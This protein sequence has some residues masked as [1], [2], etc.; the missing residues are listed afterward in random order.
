MTSD[1]APRPHVEEPSWLRIATL[2]AVLSTLLLLPFL[3]LDRGW[4]PAD[5]AL[6]HVAKAVSGRSWHDVLVIRPDVT[7][8]QHPG[9][10]AILAFV[11]RS[12]GFAPGGL[13]GFSVVFMAVLVMTAPIPGLRHRE[14]WLGAMAIA[15]V[16]EPS[17]VTRLFLGRPYLVSVAVLLYLL[18][19][20]RRL[21]Q[22]KAGRL[23]LWSLVVGIAAATWIHGSPFLW[24]IPL[25]AFV[26]SAPT[27]V[28]LRVSVAMALGVTL[29][30]IATGD[31]WQFLVQTLM[32]A[33]RAVG[34]DVPEWMLVGEF[35]S[36]TGSPLLVVAIALCTLF[37]E[38]RPRTGGDARPITI[39]NDPVWSLA[40]IGW[41]L[42]LSSMRF[43]F[44][45]GLP[46]A[47]LGLAST[48]DRWLDQDNMTPFRR[49]SLTV[50]ICLALVFAVGKDRGRRWSNERWRTYARVF[51]PRQS[52][53]LPGT[54]GILYN[55]EMNAF[56]LG[57]YS[58]PTAP[59]RFLLGF[60]PT[61]LPPD[62]LRTVYR[63]QREGA[64]D[65]GC[66]RK[67]DWHPAAG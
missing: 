8:D 13:V 43:W 23:Y 2:A 17:M 33:L 53:W 57:F 11:H 15:S 21:L 62:E 5:D 16:A 22:P 49:V 27:R 37:L 56:Y 31:P 4:V 38:R 45:W 60:E 10:H 19:T 35:K 39:L 46:A 1:Y 67:T 59:Y 36:S 30:A 48:I 41:V 32:H 44:D 65:H 25:L 64:S 7:I 55:S 52:E 18:A 54:G 61:L 24:A 6:R 28:V 47:V 20:W 58:R 26:L 50:A 12:F 14:S 63:I 66:H 40:A 42:G 51:D 9:W 34:T 29:G 3:V